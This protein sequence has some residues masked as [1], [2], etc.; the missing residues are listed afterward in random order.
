M[1]FLE[2]IQACLF[3]LIQGLSEFLPISSSG[4]LVLLGSF[5]NMGSLDLLFILVLHLGTL[6]AILSYYKTDLGKILKQ[7]QLKKTGEP[8]RL[9]Y[10]LIWATLPGILG[11]FFLLPLIKKS[12]LQSY[13]TGIGFILT[14]TYL[15]STRRLLKRK[16]TDF[17]INDIGHWSRFSFLT[18]FLIGLAQILAFFPGMSRSG[19]TII[20]ALF[21]GCPQKQAVFFSFLLAIPAILGGTAFQLINEPLPENFSIISLSLAF[22]SSW[23]FGYLALKW[24][25]YSLRNLSFPLFAFYL[26]PLGIFILIKE[27]YIS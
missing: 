18:A 20:T 19:W 8:R 16:K 14:A 12:L 3:G 22:L 2:L 9:I 27:F 11:A 1:T 5:L 4:H 24:L 17:F 6:A 26:W 10:L 15:F 25:I 13:W 21:L 23:F 7:G